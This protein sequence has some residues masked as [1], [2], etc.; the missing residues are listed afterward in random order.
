MEMVGYVYVLYNDEIP[1]HIKVGKT[2]KTPSLRAKEL[3]NGTGVVGDWLVAYFVRVSDYDEVEKKAHDLLHNYRSKK[4]REIFNTSIITGIEA[5]NK[6]A[7]SVSSTIDIPGIDGVSAQCKTINDKRSESASEIPH[8]PLFSTINNQSDEEHVYLTL[9]SRSKRINCTYFTLSDVIRATRKC[10]NVTQAQ[11][12][13]LC[14]KA[15]GLV[16]YIGERVLE[17]RKR[18]NVWKILEKEVGG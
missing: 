10:K 13:M 4:N 17:N 7:I 15:R 3:S 2:A 5:V 9:R 8:S 6:A 11:E 1:R 18:S 14:L 16:E 12:M